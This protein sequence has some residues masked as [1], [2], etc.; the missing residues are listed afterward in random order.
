MGNLL[1]HM[2]TRFKGS[3]DRASMLLK[4]ISSGKISTEQQLSGV[5]MAMWDIGGV[6]AFITCFH[7][8]AMDYCKSHPVD[9]I[10]MNAFEASCGVGVVI[11]R[12][13]IAEK[14]REPSCR[15]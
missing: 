2:A 14:V 8:A 13:Q 15:F 9:P 7:L 3:R 12:E 4:Y 11:T 6:C 1:Y 5:A 10:E